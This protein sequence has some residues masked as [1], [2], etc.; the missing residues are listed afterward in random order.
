MTK[1]TTHNG[2]EYIFYVRTGDIYS[3]VPSGLSAAGPIAKAVKR[4][5]KL[6]AAVLAAIS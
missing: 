6:Y 1:T 5:S 2:V 4:G 3:L